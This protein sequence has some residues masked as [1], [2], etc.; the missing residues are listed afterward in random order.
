MLCPGGT[1]MPIAFFRKDGKSFAAD[2]IRQK[3]I[4]TLYLHRRDELKHLENTTGN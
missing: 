2:F 3:K 4:T 1:A